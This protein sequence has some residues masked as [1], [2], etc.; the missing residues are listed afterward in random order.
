VSREDPAER[1]LDEA[2]S[3]RPRFPAPA[4]LH[5]RLAEQHLA[6]P[7]RRRSS[8]RATAAGLALGLAAAAGV[9]LYY[10][11]VVVPRAATVARL[12]AEAVNDHL[13]ILGSEHPLDVE[14]GGLHQVKPWFAGR[15]DFA[16]RVAFDGDDDFPLRGGAVSWF[17]DRR[18]AAFVYRRRLH[19]ISVFVFR[20]E[21]LA[22]PR[23]DLVPIGAARARVSDVRGFRAVVWRD[24]ELGY[25]VVSDLD[26][27]ELLGFAAK[28]APAR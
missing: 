26:R 7:A 5:R 18:A 4:A 20:A 23:A 17:L 12:D 16:P 28:L 6:A 8:L 22:W 24:G 14:S 21:G 9:A 2:L 11:R 13:R 3:Q 15:L 25:A 27:A 19:T 1:A 10:E